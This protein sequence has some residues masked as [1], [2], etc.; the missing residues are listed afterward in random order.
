MKKNMLLCVAAV[1]LIGTTC[2]GAGGPALEA[3]SGDRLTREPDVAAAAQLEGAW[4][5][6]KGHLVFPVLPLAPR[7][8]PAAVAATRFHVSPRGSD[9]NPGSQE[10][11]FATPLRARAAVR[12]LRTKGALPAGG[13]TVFFAGGTY[14]LA[15]TIELTKEDAGMPGAPILWCAM[16]NETPV[17]EGGYTVR[18][19]KPVTDPA[20]LARLPP[21]ARAHVRVADLAG[22]LRAHDPVPPYG[23]MAGDGGLFA[24]ADGS[25]TKPSAFLK[26]ITECYFGGKR[27]EPARHPNVG[28]DV[29]S[30]GDAAKNII[31]APRTDWAR[32][33]NEPDLMIT[34]YPTWLWGEWTVHV[35]AINPA[36]NTLALTPHAPDFRVPR[37]ARNYPYFLHNALAALDAP[38]EWYVDRAAGRLYVWPPEGAPADAAC[39]LGSA[40]APLL[41][42]DGVTDFELRGFVLQ[43]G[44]GN[45]IEGRGISRVTLAGNVVRR[46]GLIGFLLLDSTR[47]TVRGNVFDTFGNAAMLFSGGDRRTLTPADY[48]V[49][50]NEISRSGRRK[51]TYAQGI[52]VVGCGATI[53]NNH[54]HD[55]LSSALRLDGNDMV[56][57]SNLVERVVTESDDQGGGESWGN[58]TFA[59]RFIHNIW[60]NIGSGGRWTPC[61]QAGIR[62]DDMISNMLV[63]GNRFEN[64]SFGNFGGLQIHGGFNNT[65]DNNYFTRC[66][67]AISYQRWSF[68]EW[69]SGITN[70]ALLPFYTNATY[71]ARYPNFAT[72]PATPAPNRFTRNI[73]VGTTAARGNGQDAVF[74]G[75]V[76]FDT[77]PTS[78]RLAGLKFLDP[79][80]PESAIGPRMDDPFL[81]RSRAVFNG[82]R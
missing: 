3:L 55:L 57:A 35:A 4:R 73:V 29:F 23:Y 51:R 27:L 82:L 9:A 8:E 38:G 71:L 58:P 61:G 34:L 42:L 77:P 11:P 26:P 31:T 20:A 21:A 7:N 48:M 2:R 70:P 39:V 69:R 13:V 12:A 50:N 1:G 68:G 30:G 24:A 56:V 65:V 16:P 59:L 47:V 41:R 10:R 81:K 76:G 74:C 43:H 22:Y 45:A 63:Y 52:N 28:W 53:N 44:R 14:P 67:R 62:F 19:F 18:D 75:N 37:F 46:F 15:D 49:E 40:D 36:A 32:W 66:R 5:A 17:F 60:R 72:I 54:F 6:Y 79:L 33:A 25:L 64:C 80:P 78:E